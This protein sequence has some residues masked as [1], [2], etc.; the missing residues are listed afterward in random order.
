MGHLCS[1]LAIALLAMSLVQGAQGSQNQTGCGRRL[2]TGRILNGQS[3]R[4]RAW[5]WQ[6]SVQRHGSHICGG[7]LVSASWVVSAAHCFPQSVANSAYQLQLG[8]TRLVGESPTR[9]WSAVKQIFSHPSYDGDTFFADIALV[10]LEKP[11]VFSAAVS[12]LCLLHAA[13]HVPA[14]QPCWVT[15]WGNIRPLEAPST[16]VT[17][18]ELEVFTIDSRVCNQRMRKALAKPVGDDPV[19][20]DM[21][22]AEP[23]EGWQG[24]AP[25]DSG[26]PLVCEEGG[27]W[28][29]AGVVSWLLKTT[30]N[31]IT[32][33]A[34]G[35]PGVYNRPNAHNDWI[36]AI[37]PGATFADVNFTETRTSPPA[38]V[39]PS[40]AY[41]S[42]P[43]T[44]NRACPSATLP[45]TL[46]PLAV[47]L[48]LTL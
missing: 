42:P 31:G 35:Y 11:V 22:C 46:L 20:A 3:A 9:A 5:P 43:A 1:P 34:P 23:M 7:S 48:R 36:Q 45:G 10:E 24:T 2:V 47:L 21:L 13:A 14:G 32:T 19:K 37:M 17:L 4:D 33:V 6:V 15:G 18:Q 28:Y 12:P 29:L 30:Q 26:G 8:D 16:P 25:G 44:R 27:I 39:M 40:R 38:P 41:L